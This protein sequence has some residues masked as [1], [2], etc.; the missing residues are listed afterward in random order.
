MD[1]VRVSR[2][3]DYGE[4]HP[5]FGPLVTAQDVLNARVESGVGWY[6]EVEMESLVAVATYMT[7]FLA[8]PN[9]KVGKAGSECDE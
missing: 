1:S 2:W 5:S 6:D 3:T 9:P 8:G 4:S 7:G